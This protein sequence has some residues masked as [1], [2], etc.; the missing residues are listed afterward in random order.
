M[1]KLIYT[2]SVIL[3]FICCFMILFGCSG[4]NSNAQESLQ[5]Q[6]EEEEATIAYVCALDSF[7]MVMPKIGSDSESYHA[8]DTVHV[9][10]QRILTTKLGNL[11]R[12]ALIFQMNNYIAYGMSYF[13]AVM[14]LVHAPDVAGYVLHMLETSD[15]LYADIAK[16]EF[17]DTVAVIEF[18]YNSYMNLTLFA[19]LQNVISTAN[20]RED[21]FMD[22]IGISI[23]SLDVLAN[24]K[25][26]DK[27]SA[28]EINRISAPIEAATFFNTFCPLIQPFAPSRQYL[29]DHK[30]KIIE[31]A[32]YF[33]KYA[34]PMYIGSPI[35]MSDEDYHTFMLQST[36]YKIEMLRMLTHIVSL[37][38]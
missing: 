32:K 6:E 36:K 25:R 31:M 2:R 7:A 14:G 17:Q 29:V 5:S 22:N 27:Y 1:K 18:G 11:E 34:N 21:I 15:S 37:M 24:L 10:A 20:G 4:T 23:Q 19:H 30:A 16:E 35:P 33:D 8:A 38:E 12:Q 13:S 26:K 3:L 9:I 28:D